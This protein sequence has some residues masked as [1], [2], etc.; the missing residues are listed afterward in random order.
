M[1]SRRVCN[2]G[3]GTKID[4]RMTIQIERRIDRSVGKVSTDYHL[5][6]VRGTC[7]SSDHDG[8]VSLKRDRLGIVGID[9]D[10]PRPKRRSKVPSDAK[11]AIPFSP[12]ATSMPSAWIAEEVALVAATAPDP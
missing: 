8:A 11:R 6:A 2:L 4:Q 10:S 7:A 9:D 12:T 3:A 5:I 1:R